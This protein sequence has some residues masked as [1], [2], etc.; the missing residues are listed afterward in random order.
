MKIIEELESLEDGDNPALFAAATGLIDEEGT[1]LFDFKATLAALDALQLK[2]PNHRLLIG[3][4]GC[5]DWSE[6]ALFGEREETAAEKQKR[7]EKELKVKQAEKAKIQRQIEELKK[8]QA[9]LQ[10]K[11]NEKI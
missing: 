2:Y 10:E 11:L 9:K 5:W 7:L 6:F 3:N 1:R 8:R 4:K